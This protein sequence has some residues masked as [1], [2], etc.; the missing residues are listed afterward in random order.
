MGQIQTNQSS[1]LVGLLGKWG[2][3]EQLSSIV[4]DERHPYDCDL[5][6]SFIELRFLKADLILVVL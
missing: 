2:N 5:V 3:I 1:D 6:I 4:L